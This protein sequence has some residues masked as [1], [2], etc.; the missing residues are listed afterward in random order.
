MYVSLMYVFMVLVKS[1]PKLHHF[2]SCVGTRDQG[3]VVA[4]TELAAVL[5]EIWAAPM[6]I[7]SQTC[8]PQM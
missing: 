8:L 5:P 7:F 3:V 2:H 4:G 6:A 1:S